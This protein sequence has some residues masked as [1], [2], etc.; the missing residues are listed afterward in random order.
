MRYIYPPRAKKVAKYEQ[1][2]DFESKGIWLGQRKY[3]GDRCPV[4]LT[5]DSIV[6][7]NRHGQKQKHSLS[8]A[9]RDSLLSLNIGKGETWLDG[10]LLNSID[11]LVLFDVIQL[12]GE[13][14]HS[15]TQQDRLVLLNQI[16][17]CPTETNSLMGHSVAANLYLAQ[18]WDRD[19]QLR[20]N[21]HIDLDMIEG[22]VLRRKD[23]FLGSWGSSPYEVDWMV[24]F[25]KPSKKYRH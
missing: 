23:S 9:L 14:L 19:F 6:L 15:T 16:C 12:D 18:V 10:E 11:T 25:R 2:Q 8:P 3:N 24:R 1:L 13:Y 20:F 22:L 21:D 7:W 5:Q 17:G 4:Q